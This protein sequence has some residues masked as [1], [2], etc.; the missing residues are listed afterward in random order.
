M[1]AG[2]VRM[3][4]DVIVPFEALLSFA[5]DLW[6]AAGMPRD[7]AELAA[8]VICDATLRGVDTH[9]VFL[10]TLYVRRLRRGLIKARPRMSFEQPRSAIGVLDAD[11]GMGHV[12]T[13]RAME[14][15]VRMAREAGVATVLV[16]NSNHFGAA[17][18]Y[19]MQAARQ[20]H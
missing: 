20:N 6:L 1:N 15:A 2:D 18:Y 8:R 10:L 17:A 9:G 5:A 14:H 11:H 16:K 3:D 19:V 13:A 4:H 12:A 7:E